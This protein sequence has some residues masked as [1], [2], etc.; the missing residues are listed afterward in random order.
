[1]K[2][3]DLPR[4]ER[5][6]SPSNRRQIER[7]MTT[8]SRLSVITV[9]SSMDGGTLERAVA[10]ANKSLELHM[11]CNAFQASGCCS[12]SVRSRWSELEG[13]SLFNGLIEQWHWKAWQAL[14]AYYAF[15]RAF[16]ACFLR[17]SQTI[18]N[19]DGIDR[20]T[21]R[22]GAFKASQL[23]FICTLSS[24]NAGRYSPYHHISAIGYRTAFLSL[25]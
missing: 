7:T 14:S 9:V 22:K 3:G 8:S 10:T 12:A 19:K 20:E 23:V 15:W 4:G 13:F 21:G 24:Q 17:F 16:S 11:R 2:M 18:R 5:T 1:M 25:L 6:M